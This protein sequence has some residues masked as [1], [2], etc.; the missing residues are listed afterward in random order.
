MKKEDIRRR[1]KAHKCIIAQDEAMQASER[2]FRQLEKTAAF[3][4]ADNILMYH[5]LP[6]ELSTHAF[7]DKWGSRKNI[8]LP[9]VNGVNL[10]IL[11]YK[12]T[13]LHIGAFN[14]EEPEGEDLASIN[15]IELIIVP[16]VAYDRNG[17]RVGRGK[18]YYDRLLAETTATKIGIGYDF[19]FIGEDID[20]DDHD[21]SVD[22][23][24]TENRYFHV[25]HHRR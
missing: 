14:I 10:D 5:S 13:Q 11:P 22:I 21:V 6:D 23:I 2:V 24:I 16:G 3:I 19:Q 7:L 1:I 20:T 8:F 25:H 17:N 18:G 4:L 12:N 15:D 9:R